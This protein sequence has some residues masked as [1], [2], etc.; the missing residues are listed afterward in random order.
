MQALIQ[1]VLTNLAA[2]LDQL[3][4]TAKEWTDTQR[5]RAILNLAFAKFI[6]HPRIR[7]PF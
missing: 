3:K 5:L 1:S 7:L 2:F 6:L 4:S